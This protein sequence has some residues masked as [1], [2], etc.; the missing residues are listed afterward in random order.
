M[1][2][3]W[4]PNDRPLFTVDCPIVC[5]EKDMISERLRLHTCTVATV[6]FSS[7]QTPLD[8]F[9]CEYIKARHAPLVDPR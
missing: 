7:E 2:A 8:G 4:S 9:C 6:T 3:Q 1:P 5:K